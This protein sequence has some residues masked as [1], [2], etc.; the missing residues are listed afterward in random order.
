MLLE[1]VDIQLTERRRRDYKTELQEFIQRK[2]GQVLRYTL[3]DQTGPD[4][5]KVF[6]VAVSLNETVVGTGTGRSKKEA[7]QAAAAAALEKLTAEE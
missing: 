5:A 6:T 7:E 4:H 3:T 2:P 1:K